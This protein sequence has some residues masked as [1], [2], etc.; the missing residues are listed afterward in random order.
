MAD[1]IKGWRIMM[2]S[3]WAV[4]VNREQIKVIA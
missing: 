3:S 4:W 1:G 2:M